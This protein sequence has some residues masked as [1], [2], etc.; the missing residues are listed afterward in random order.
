M[1]PK[2][3]MIALRIDIKH[4]GFDLRRTNRGRRRVVAHSIALHIPLDRGDESHCTYLS[5]LSG[6]NP[7]PHSYSVLIHGSLTFVFVIEFISNG[8]VTCVVSQ[9]RYITLRQFLTMYKQANYPFQGAIEYS[10]PLLF[11]AFHVGGRNEGGRERGDTW[12]SQPALT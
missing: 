9:V 10:V 6:M 8:C 12:P 1:Q 11:P 2:L 5:L 3:L 4:L 7:T